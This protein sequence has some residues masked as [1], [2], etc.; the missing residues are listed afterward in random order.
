MDTSNRRLKARAEA[1]HLGRTAG[2]AVPSALARLDA[3]PLE[4]EAQRI[5]V[6]PLA[7][8]KSRSACFHQ[9]QARPEVSPEWMRPDCAQACHELLVLPPS[10]WCDEIA[11][12]Q[13]KPS[14]KASSIS[15]CPTSPALA[16]R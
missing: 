15:A 8:S 13:R 7:R 12:P 16:H 1:T 2:G 14:G 9:S 6:H 5:K 4:G 11:T 3:A 10:T